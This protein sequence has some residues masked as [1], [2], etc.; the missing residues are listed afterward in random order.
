M[1]KKII[2]IWILFLFISNIVSAVDLNN[3][4]ETNDIENTDIGLN[5]YF[6]C[7]SIKLTEGT[8]FFDTYQDENGKWWFVDPEG[9]A[10][11]SVGVCAVSPGYGYA[12]N[13]N[14]LE[15]YGNYE[16]WVNATIDRFNDW[17]FNT[18]GAWSE[19]NLF[20]NIPYTYTLISRRDPRWNVARNLPDV[21]DPCWKLH[22]KEEIE[23]FTKETKDDPYLIGYWIDN[24]MN[25]GPDSFDL[26]TILEEYMCF[27]YEY[28]RPG[29][30]VAVEFLR[31]RYNDDV[32]EFNSVWNMNIECF[33]DLY[34]IL[35]LGRKGWLSQNFNKKIKGDIKAFN[36]LVAETYFNITTS[37]IRENDP[38]HLILG[39]RFHLEGA[40]EEV[41]KACGK[42]CDVVSINHY[43]ESVVVYSPML[44]LRCR[45]CGVV[46]LDKWMGSYYEISGKPLL[47]GEFSCNS[48]DSDT[49]NSVL[50]GIS[51][52]VINQRNRGRYFEWYAKK[53]LE[54][55]YVIGYHWFAYVDKHFGY[56]T[57]CGLLNKYDEEYDF[58]NYIS[59]INGRVYDL[60]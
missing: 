15:K 30:R 14:I 40:P 27:N 17:G 12:Y 50:V 8:G 7:K 54:S 1:R 36:E 51:K 52:L 13:E 45:F 34:D 38:N 20:K 21:F 26:N 46:P 19:H 53:C 58:V 6:G 49:T 39:V 28:M 23:N 57:N 2:I 43:R 11:Y 24:E 3:T 48:L 22:I 33:D 18:L 55:P 37:L 4:N 16:G 60:H 42:Y 9:H 31:E 35:K 25:W 5:E 59:D 47:S 29:K 56:D 10:F 32:D 44:A 41:I